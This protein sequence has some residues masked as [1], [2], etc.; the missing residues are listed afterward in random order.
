MDPESPKWLLLDTKKGPRGSE[1][2]RANT[3]YDFALDD[4]HL[5]IRA[6]P[7]PQKKGLQFYVVNVF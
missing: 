3:A 1:V 7:P 6:L 2:G 5:G 4:N